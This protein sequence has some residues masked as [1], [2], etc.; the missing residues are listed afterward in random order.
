MSEPVQLNQENLPRVPAEIS[1]PTYD[2]S[3]VTAGIVHIGVG[4]FH[5]SHEAYYTDELMN[6]GEAFDWGIC[7]VGLREAD[8]KICGVLK[9]QNFLYTLIVKHPGGK[10]ENRVIGSLVDFM[11]G[12]DDPEAVIERMSNPEDQDRLPHHHGR[13]LQCG[14]FHGRIRHSQSRCAPRSGESVATEAGVWIS[15]GGA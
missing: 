13:R 12:C 5:R 1:R 8:R 10:I 2:R 9:N 4:G 15:D 11:M 6:S 14:S 7:G 3:K